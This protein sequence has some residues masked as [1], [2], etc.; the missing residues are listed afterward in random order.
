MRKCNGQVCARENI[1]YIGSWHGSTVTSDAKVKALMPP[2]LQAEEHMP[3]R[4][5]PPPPP[6]PPSHQ[7]PCPLR[8][9]VRC[10][11]H[12]DSIRSAVRIIMVGVE[13]E[14]AWAKT[15]AAPA[16]GLEEH[17]C[18]RTPFLVHCFCDWLPGQKT[19]PRVVSSTEGSQPAQGAP[20][21]MAASPKCERRKK[22]STSLIGECEACRRRRAGQRCTS[23]LNFPSSR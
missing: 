3:P 18:S 21:S 14:W 7:M 11:L 17:P 8:A 9:P 2:W 15:C 16:G 20:C 12:D 22:P 10:A 19:P 23:P 5:P 13:C 6:P 4:R 1:P